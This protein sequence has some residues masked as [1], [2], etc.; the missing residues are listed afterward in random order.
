[1]SRITSLGLLGG[2]LAMIVAAGAMAFE[3]TKPGLARQRSAP[4]E[5]IDAAILSAHLQNL[6]GETALP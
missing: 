3:V 6:R 1:M 5:S 2:M 4:A